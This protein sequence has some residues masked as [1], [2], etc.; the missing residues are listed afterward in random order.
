MTA[1]PQLSLA[2]GLRQLRLSDTELWNRYLALGGTGDLHQLRDHVR[3][4]TCPDRHDHNIIAQALN[5]AFV[6]EG[7]DH[8]VAYHDLYRR[9]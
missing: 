1:T 4:G 2:D 3:G 5:D 6:D 9:P 7:H 8:A